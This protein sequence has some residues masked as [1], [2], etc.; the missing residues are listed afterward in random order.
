M[1]L[2]KKA[3]KALKEFERWVAPSVL[4]ECLDTSN[5]SLPQKF[6]TS[7]MFTDLTG[8]WQLCEAHSPE[9]VVE[10]L[11]A[12]YSLTHPIVSQY[13]GMA[14]K[15]E[16]DAMMLVFGAPIPQPDHAQQAIRC[17]VQMQEAM[18]RFR[19]EVCRKRGWPAVYLRIGIAS[20]ETIVGPIGSEE[21]VSYTAIGYVVNLAARLESLNKEYNSAILCDEATHNQTREL[22]IGDLVPNVKVMPS[23]N[24]LVNIYIVR[25]LQ[26]T[27]ARDHLWRA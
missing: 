24:K 5:P 17:A 13:N 1:A 18:I 19:E 9:D 22:V 6:E 26:K 16:G 4:K 11:N 3:K 23:A 25:G 2:K 8:F 10:L 12:Y 27:G 7:I 15:M 21:R 20:G 14:D